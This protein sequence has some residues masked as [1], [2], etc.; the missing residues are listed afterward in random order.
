MENQK[1]HIKKQ[2]IIFLAC[3]VLIITLG[4]IYAAVISDT[5]I[6]VDGL[7]EYNGTLLTSNFTELNYLDGY[8]PTNTQIVYGDGTKLT[9]SSNFVKTATGVGIGTSIPGT[10]LEVVESGLNSLSEVAITGY[11]DQ[12]VYRPG[13]LLRKSNS[14]TKGTLSATQDGD[15]LGQIAWYGVDTAPGWENAAYLAAVQDGVATGTQ[16]PTA[17]AFATNDGLES[18]KERLRIKPDG[19][20]YVGDSSDGP[21]YA[22]SHIWGIGQF[23]V[24]GE[25]DYAKLRLTTVGTGGD[26]SW[27]AF[28]RA[29]GTFDSPTALQSGDIFASI[30]GVGLGTGGATMQHGPQIDFLVTENWIDGS[31]LGNAIEFKTIANG[32]TS[33]VSTLY[34]GGGNVG[35]G[36]ASPTSRLHVYENVWDSTAPFINLSNVDGSSNQGNVL[37]LKGGST[38]KSSYVLSAE[39]LA[40]ES[41]LYVKGTG[42]VGI[43]TASPRYP[44]EVSGNN[45]TISIYA[46]QNISATGYITRTS[47]YD[48]SKGS[49]LDYIK[50]ASYYQD[51]D[52]IDHSKFYGYVSY[53]ME[54]Q[55][56]YR[57]VVEDYEEEVCDKVEVENVI[58]SCSWIGEL[59]GCEEV[60]EITIETQCNN[61]IKQRTTYPYTKTI[62]EEG[63][64]L[65]QEINVLRQGLYELK[66]EVCL[67][68][69]TYS[70]C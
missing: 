25:A 8:L 51:V 33:Q 15:Y 65:D 70:F 26:R 62:T 22:D 45:A 5:Q 4:A 41:L 11:N 21:Y 34:L 28:D 30:V 53:D 17:L 10:N 40:G 9:S 36:T 42:N 58:E 46:E 43:G 23:H 35:I 44:L 55:D 3:F 7:F 68:D 64:S 19:E 66:T 16:V 1:K 38:D 61:V 60:I 57:P 39:N 6:D 54:E 69:P 24:R 67:K 37:Y 32:D 20:I 13:L 29:R 49:A 18:T 59:F 63:V 47:I 27:L 52:G 14:D 31:N 50:D 12:N 56:L 48:K 2:G